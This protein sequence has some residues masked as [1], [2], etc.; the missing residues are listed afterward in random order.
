MRDGN[1][2]LSAQL[3]KKISTFYVRAIV[4]RA[5]KICAIEMHRWE[6]VL[7]I[8]YPT[9]RSTLLLIHYDNIAWC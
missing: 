9:A 3:A 7:L 1:E 8:V 2:L 5:I 6:L 4:D